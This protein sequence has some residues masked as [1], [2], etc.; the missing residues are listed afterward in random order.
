MAKECFTQILFFSLNK[1]ASHC[2]VHISIK[3]GKL[4]Y[5]LKKKIKVY[6]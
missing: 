4:I 1:N 6:I 3:L 5:G 2:A